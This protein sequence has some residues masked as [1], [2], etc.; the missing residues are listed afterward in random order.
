[1]MK[2]LSNLSRQIEHSVDR[3]SISTLL[4]FLVVGVF[5]CGGVF[6]ALSIFGEG[7]ESTGE[8]VEISLLDSIYFSVVTI[9]SL[10]YGDFKPIGIGRVVAGFEVLYGLVMLALFVAK[11]AGNRQSSIIKAYYVNDQVY[12]LERI[13]ADLAESRRI[14]S[15]VLEG[16]RKSLSARTVDSL[17]LQVIGLKKYLAVQKK[18]DMLGSPESVSELSRLTRELLK[19]GKEILLISRN[20]TLT[21]MRRRHFEGLAKFCF[22]VALDCSAN[23]D[24]SKR[25]KVQEYIDEEWK[26]QNSVRHLLP[27]KKGN[28]TRKT[29]SS[30]DE[31][32]IESVRNALPAQPWPKH[33]HKKVASDLGVSNMVA[34]KVISILI[35]RGEVNRQWRGEILNDELL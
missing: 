2:H 34:H 12:R 9:S 27:K 6:Y 33:V 25:I 18:L 4:V 7:I 35:E 31:S 20:Q 11:L 10:G 17:Y 21:Y 5:V 14:M 28:P 3:A 23:H 16:G 30:I 26:K 24:Q 15:E 32:L 8:P 22:K 29:K 1:M 13:R 19:A